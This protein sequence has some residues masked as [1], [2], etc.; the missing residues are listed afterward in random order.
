MHKSIHYHIKIG[1]IEWYEYWNPLSVLGYG[2]LLLSLFKCT[3]QI[4]WNYRR[5][6]TRGWSISMVLMDLI[7]AAFSMASGG[8]SI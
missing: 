1:L 2:K 4:Y 8:L 7:G 5:K 6:S 3:P